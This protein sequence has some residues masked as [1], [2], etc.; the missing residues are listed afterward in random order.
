MM[1]ITINDAEARTL[2]RYLDH[3]RIHALG[4]LDGLDELE[5]RRP[6][7]PSG[8]SCLG[9]IRHLTR[10]VERF[11]FRAVVAG[12]QETIDEL[13]RDQTSAWEIPDDESATVIFE[14]YRL[15]TEFLGRDYRRDLD[16]RRTGMVAGRSLRRVAIGNGARDRSSRSD[17]NRHPYRSS[18]RRP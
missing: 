8:W 12:D 15:H 3:Q 1:S 6:I 4:I 13:A 2:L 9:M 7:L 10:D 16:G 5:L 18:Q 11:W 17:G 14:R